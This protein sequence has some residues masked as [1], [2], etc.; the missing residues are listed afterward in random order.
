[1]GAVYVRGGITLSTEGD[2]LHRECGGRGRTEGRQALIH[3]PMS[4]GE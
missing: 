3:D 4:Y 2:G 1:M